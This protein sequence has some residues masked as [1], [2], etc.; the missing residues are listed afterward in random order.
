MK[1]EFG[2][3]KG[4]LASVGVAFARFFCHLQN[5]FAVCEMLLVQVITPTTNYSL[6][7]RSI[8]FFIIPLT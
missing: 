7:R 3:P 4:F 6:I 2:L 8:P 1:K 5:V